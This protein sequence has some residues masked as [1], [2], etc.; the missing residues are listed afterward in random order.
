MSPFTFER[1]GERLKHAE[2]VN[3]D[4]TGSKSLNFID[5]SNITVDHTT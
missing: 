4:N 5:F 3:G 1:R 2:V